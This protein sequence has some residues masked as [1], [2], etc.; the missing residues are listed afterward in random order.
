MKFDFFV[1]SVLTLL[2][3]DMTDEG[4]NSEPDEGLCTIQESE[5]NGK[6]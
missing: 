4:S 2:D 3:T 1:A 6:F 5:E